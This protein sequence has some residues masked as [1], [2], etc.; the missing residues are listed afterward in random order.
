MTIELTEA[1]PPIDLAMPRA[2]ALALSDLRV[3]TVIPTADEDVWRVSGVQRVGALRVAGHDVRITPKLPISRLFFMLGYANGRRIWR[4]SDV[5]LDTD[6]DLM[7]AVAQAFIR[8][9][10]IALSTGLLQG[11]RTVDASESVVRGRIDFNRQLKRRTGIP[12]PIEISYDEFT[13]D[14]DE[15][16]VLA[17]AIDRL[18]RLPQLEHGARRTLKHFSRLFIGVD[19]LPRGVPTPRVHFN[20]RN[21]RY[22]PAFELATLILR[23]GSLEHRHG[24]TRATGFLLNVAEIFEDFLSEAIREKIEPLGGKVTAQMR[25]TL[26]QANRLTIRPDIAWNVHGRVVAIL[27]AKYKAEKPAGYPHAD[28]YQML[29]YC[30]RWGLDDGHLIYAAGQTEPIVH[31]IVGTSVRVHCHA[32]NLD[33]QPSEILARVGELTTQ[34]ARLASAQDRRVLA[35]H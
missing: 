5:D 7:A 9:V 29:A 10:R 6:T 15:N 25:G 19:L 28:V 24:T 27:D 30:T 33:G 35:E 31:E 12:S 14:I 34:V 23:N 13:A 2:V 22:R 20:R 18:L 4:D 32:L 16:R 17:G 1:S 8:Q 21:Q 26:D 3:A 11:Y